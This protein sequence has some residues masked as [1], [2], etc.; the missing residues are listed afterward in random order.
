MC[1]FICISMLVIVVWVRN[2]AQRT[3]TF[4]NN[5]GKGYL[6][7]IHLP[8][9]SQVSKENFPPQ[10]LDLKTI[11]GPKDHWWND[12]ISSVPQHWSWGYKECS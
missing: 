5:E 9:V 1:A 8:R 7:N 12:E 10:D 6:K 11:W 3:R 2:G 4:T